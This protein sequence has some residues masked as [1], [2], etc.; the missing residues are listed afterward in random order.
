MVS[1]KNMKNEGRWRRRETK[2]K[3]K[4]RIICRA[5]SIQAL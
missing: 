2:E 5:L 4:K 3:K 1:V